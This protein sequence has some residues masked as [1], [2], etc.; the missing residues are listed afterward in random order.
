MSLSPAEL[1]EA[2]RWRYATKAFDPSRTIP[3]ETWAALEVP[4]D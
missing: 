1:L 4:G 3:P 2:Q